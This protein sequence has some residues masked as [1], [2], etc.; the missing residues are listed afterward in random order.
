MR[1]PTLVLAFAATLFGSALHAQDF[2]KKQAAADAKQ[3][4]QGFAKSLKSELLAAMQKGGPEHALGVCN[5]EAMPIT[6]KAGSANDSMVSRVSLKNR[7]PDNVPNDWQREILEQFDARAADGED[8]APMASVTV[9]DV[10]GK[11]QL[12]FM[13]A[14]PTEAPC[15]AC[16]GQTLSA[17]VQSKLDELYPEDKATGYSLGDVRGAIVVIKDYE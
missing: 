9:A 6:A 16:H 7:N 13:K 12:R 5:I 1:T 15:L 8:I 17:E 10:D 2:D 11:K 14:V 3:V 4:V